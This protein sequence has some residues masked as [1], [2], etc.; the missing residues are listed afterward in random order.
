M[1]LTQDCFVAELV[2]NGCLPASE[3]VN[4]ARK[5][6]GAGKRINSASEFIKMERYGEPATTLCKMID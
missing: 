6:K 4:S 3:G 5:S 1:S 2:H